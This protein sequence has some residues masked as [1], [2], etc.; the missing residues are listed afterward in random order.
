MACKCFEWLTNL[1][2]IAGTNIPSIHKP[3][4]FLPV[5]DP[6]DWSS[7]QD[8]EVGKYAVLIGINEYPYIVADS[9]SGCVN[10]VETMYKI[11]TEKFDFPPDNIRVLTDRRATKQNIL[12]RIQWLVYGSKPGDELVIHYSGHGSQVRDR[13]GDELNDYL[14]EIL[15]PHDLDFDDPLTDDMIHEIFKHKIDGASLTFICDSCHSGTINRAIRKPEEKSKTKARF[16]V[17]PFDIRARS[18][19]RKLNVNRI[20]AKEIKEGERSTQTHVLISGCRDDQTSADA[21]VDG[22]WQGA[23][24]SSLGKAI[25]N[26]PY[27]D[28]KTIHAEVISILN[29]NDFEQRPQLSGDDSLITGRTIFGGKP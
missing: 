13:N 25:S 8:R 17:P 22:R 2:K 23:F 11:L 14:D 29:K 24:T 4:S 6:T 27:R 5:D 28:W 21:Q 3:E 19:G 15:C 18:F 1:F 20:G 26:N 7:L 12:D 9:L 16:I 10:D